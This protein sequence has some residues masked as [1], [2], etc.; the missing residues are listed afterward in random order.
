MI[1]LAVSAALL[2]ATA[3][4]A[5]A[6]AAPPDPSALVRPG[7]APVLVRS[8][9][10][11]GDGNDELVIASASEEPSEFGLP[12]PYL[13]V[14]A[15]GEAGWERVFD[16][17]GHAPPGAGAPG[18]M[19]QTAGDF[20]VGQSIQTLELADLLADGS[21]EIVVAVANAGAAEGPVELWVL[22]AEPGPELRTDLYR[23]SARGGRVEVLGDTVT[24]EYGVYRKRDPGCCPSVTETL[25]IGSVDGH[26][27]VVATD[28]RR[29]Q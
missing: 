23:R 2:V 5:D 9:D 6:P 7:A 8:G 3:C 15:E 21:P 18:E 17:S 14:F 12:V 20:A 27:D 19:L 24:F 4:P 28:R 29:N 11:D 1:R 25:T 10:L 13:E 16:A 22:G 26:I